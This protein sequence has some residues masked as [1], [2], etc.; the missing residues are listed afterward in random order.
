MTIKISRAKELFYY[1]TSVTGKERPWDEC[2]KG[3]F[4]RVING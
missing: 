4:L 2:R 1:V 3:V